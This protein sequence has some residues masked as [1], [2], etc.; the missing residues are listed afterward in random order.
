MTFQFLGDTYSQLQEQ[1]DLNGLFAILTNTSL[2][3]GLPHLVYGDFSGE[4]PFEDKNPIMAI[5]YPT[6]WVEEYFD[7]GLLYAD[8]VN[9]HLL[10][11]G[12]ATTWGALAHSAADRRFFDRAASAGL[13]HGLSMPLFG[14]QGTKFAL[15][16]SSCDP[17]HDEQMMQ[18]KLLG[19]MCHAI[20]LEKMWPAM[21]DNVTLSETQKRVLELVA[22]GRTTTEVADALGMTIDGVNYQ[23]R[24]V[25]EKLGT[26]NL[27]HSVA[28][29]ITT[30]LIW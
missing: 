7:E 18:A 5:S 16:F 20:Y 12:K 23:L 22:H 4:D 1:T 26:R 24:K 10:S 28:V 30:K 25:A 8:P 15:S 21:A 2:K 14:P 29:A 9:R 17:I 6:D 19:E 27:T 11:A 3:L 13:D